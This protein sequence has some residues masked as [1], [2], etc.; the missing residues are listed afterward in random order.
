[1]TIP[2]GQTS[3]SFDLTVWDD[4]LI[5]GPQAVR[6]S[7]F[8]VGYVPAGATIEVDD[9]ETAAISIEAPSLVTESDGWMPLRG[10]I[11]LN[12]TPDRDITV[13]LSTEGAGVVALPA[14]VV[15]LAGQTSA[16]FSIQVLDDLEVGGTR[17]VMISASVPGWGSEARRIDVEDNEPMDLFIEADGE[18]GAD[19]KLPNQKGRVKI[20]RALA[21]DLVVDLFSNDPTK[22][23]VPPFVIIPA[24]ETMALFGIARAEGT[25]PDSSEVT[26]V[27]STPGWSRGV[28]TIRFKKNG[29]SHP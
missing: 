25:S 19:G 7:A 11:T 1:M 2:A 12:P 17:E 6:V 22:A 29:T 5:D 26:L 23:A 8:A 16:P 24:G 14:T 15:V 9:N 20:L 3:A 13:Y 28:V 4:T 10:K 18:E 21:F 27:A